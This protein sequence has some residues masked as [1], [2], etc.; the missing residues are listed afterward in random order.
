[1]KLVKNSVV[2]ELPTLTKVSSFDFDFRTGTEDKALQHGGVFT[3]D[4]K[5]EVRTLELEIGIY[6][7][8]TR[9]DYRNLVDK[10]K[11]YA[12]RRGQ[13]F[14][15]DD[16]R[17]INIECL[18]S[19]QEDFEDGY[20]G[21]KGTLTLD[22]ICIDPFEYSTSAIKGSENVTESPH[23][24]TINNP[25]TADTPLKLTITANANNPAVTLVNETDNNRT[26][27]Y[28][29]TGFT[30]GKV[31]VIDSAEGIVTRDTTNTI[32]DMGGTFINLLPG[33]NVIKYT[34]AVAVIAYEFTPRWL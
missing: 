27:G 6:N 22:F 3:G 2:Y 34:G 24:F 1:M 33:G 30:A 8:G 16:D 7:L 29:D 10:I 13:R 5:A 4:G 26:F 14:Y 12:S 17:Y 25:G 9:T 32:N 20:H 18:K 15:R 11:L 31:V 19:V 28:Q 23:E 21:I